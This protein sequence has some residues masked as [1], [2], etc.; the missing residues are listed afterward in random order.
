VLL[1]CSRPIRAQCSA[2]WYFLVDTSCLVG[3][4]AQCAI[5]LTAKCS[6]PSPDTQTLSGEHR[7]VLSALHHS[8]ALS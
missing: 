5:G 6:V 3:M 2:S 1:K 7:F 8:L 4:M